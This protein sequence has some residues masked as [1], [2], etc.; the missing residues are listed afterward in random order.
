MPES[1]DPVSV[2][3]WVRAWETAVRVYGQAQSRADRASIWDVSAAEAMAAASADLARTWRGLLAARPVPHWV[4]SAVETAADVFEEQTD[5]WRT[6]ESSVRQ[7][8][9]QEIAE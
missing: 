4:S 7:A 6:R 3:E 8:L 1:P 9:Q 5:A 2:D